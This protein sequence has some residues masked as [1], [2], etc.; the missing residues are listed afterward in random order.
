LILRG[1]LRNNLSVRVCITRPIPDPGPSL[2]AEKGLEVSVRDT[3]VP[4]EE[5]ELAR[6]AGEFPV[7]VTLLTDPV[8]ERV[9][10]SGVRLVAQL[11]VGHDNVDIA[12]ATRH[13]VAVTNTPGVLTEA[14]AELTWALILAVARHVVA[15]DQY[16]R[17]G[18]FRAWGATLFLGPELAGK[19]L[20]ILGAGRIG[21]RVGE[22]AHAF[23][24]KVIYLDL[25]PSERL[26]SIGGRRADL[27]EILREADVVSVHLPLTSETSRLIGEKEL[28]LMKPTAVIVNTARGPILDESALARA[29]K[30]GWIAGA[31][32]DV[33]ENEPRVHPDLP[34]LDSVVLLPHIGSA[35]REARS[36]MSRAVAENVVAF[37]DGQKP[38]NILNP[39]V[40]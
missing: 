5:D 35:T 18:S 27:H 25:V 36:A 17:E 3:N 19:T 22:I 37:V 38:P 40:L 31:G 7:L 15:S 4:P 12:A 34:G 24:M 26:D 39:E 32:L 23:D 9:L 2:L 30:E 6:L 8:T 20:G 33:Y 29:L 21:T 28:R 1:Q 16:T 13:G 10:S 14:T 11:A